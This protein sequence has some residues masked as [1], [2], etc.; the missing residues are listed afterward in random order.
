MKSKNDIWFI[1]IP[2]S[3]LV[4]VHILLSAPLKVPVIWPD[5]YSYIFSAMKIAGAFHGNYLPD[6]KFTGSI[7]YSLLLAPIFH[8]IRDPVTAYKAV[9]IVNSFL[10]GFIYISLYLFARRITEVSQWKSLVLAFVISFYPAYFLQSFYA[11]TDGFTPALF[12]LGIITFHYLIKKRDTASLLLFCLVLVIQNLVHIRFYPFSIAVI[13]LLIPIARNKALNTSFYLTIVFSIICSFIIPLII[14]QQLFPVNEA[15]DELFMYIAR[16]V[17]SIMEIIVLIVFLVPIVFFILKRDY[18]SLV[19]ILAGYL[20]GLLSQIHKVGFAFG[21]IYLAVMFYYN[22]H[23]KTTS[24]RILKTTVIFIATLILSL[25]LFPDLKSTLAIA[26]IFIN[27][28]GYLFGTVYYALFATALLLGLGF[29]YAMHISLT[30][31]DLVPGNSQKIRLNNIGRAMPN[32]YTLLIL[33]TLAML[34]ITLYPTTYDVSRYRA[35]HLFYGRYLEV[36]LAPFLL[37]GCIE[38]MNRRNIITQLRKDYILI[39]IFALTALIPLLLTGNVIDEEIAVQS[40]FS[41][42]LPRAI[43]K[44]INIL[45]YFSIGIGIFIFLLALNK[46][47]WKVSL[48]GLGMMFLINSAFAYNYVIK[49]FQIEK[50][51]QNR[52]VEIVHEYADKSSKIAIDTRLSNGIYGH[53]I[54]RYIYLLN[55]YNID[56]VK[57]PTIEP[58]KYDF[59]ISSPLYGFK[60]PESKFL[61]VETNGNGCLWYNTNKATKKLRL[62][63]PSY[64]NI[65]LLKDYVGGIYTNGFYLDKFINGKA[66]VNIPQEIDSSNISVMLKVNCTNPKG[67]KLIVW[68]NNNPVLDS[69]VHYGDQTFDINLNLQN[70]IQKLQL[71]FYSDLTRK[72]DKKLNGI[73]IEDL[74]IITHDEENDQENADSKLSGVGNVLDFDRNIVPNLLITNPHDTVILPVL[75]SNV[76]NGQDQSQ[77]I[78]WKDFIFM[79]SVSKNYINFKHLHLDSSQRYSSQTMQLISPQQAGKYFIDFENQAGYEFIL[80]EYL[81]INKTNNLP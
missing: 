6:I 73:S 66:I 3:L 2:Y 22:L 80:K 74:Q 23:H 79:K 12:I 77:Y 24:N 62:Y 38:I 67:S 20:T 5:A 51:S 81:T 47:S 70:S 11:Y 50:L 56:I 25:I 19:S 64:L 68:L 52:L 9:L 10:N 13:I 35:D 14:Q 40:V 49:Y 32:A 27:W 59:V 30:N 54:L 71:N 8:F 65:F 39:I 17:A 37:L 36:M 76:R 75:F 31:N 4:I 60:Y 29:K 44:N 18:W 45:L 15:Q 55:H 46:I 78:T 26:S 41:F 53:N 16:H 57:E 69:P 7:G 21:A 72:A 58:N 1:L 48:I 42:F 61:G 34:I 43:F 63:S 33:S 28:V